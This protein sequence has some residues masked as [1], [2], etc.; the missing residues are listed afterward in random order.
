MGSS[1][2]MVNSL[3]D[4][5]GLFMEIELVCRE[6][7]HLKELHSNMMGRE[8]SKKTYIYGLGVRARLQHPLRDHAE[9]P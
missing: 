1:L 2:K 6:K 5:I 3:K 4:R 8:L 7:F 9:K